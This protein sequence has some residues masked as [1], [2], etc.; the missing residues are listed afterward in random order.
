MIINGRSS[1]EFEVQK[2]VVVYVVYSPH[3]R[4]FEEEIEHVVTARVLG[5]VKSFEAR[6]GLFCFREIY[7]FVVVNHVALEPFFETERAKI[8]VVVSHKVVRS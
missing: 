3:I 7:L 2:L 6:V 4:K 5:F 8:V 1:K